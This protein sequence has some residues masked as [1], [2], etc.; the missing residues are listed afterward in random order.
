VKGSFLLFK[1]APDFRGKE[2]KS[3]DIEWHFSSKMVIRI[4]GFWEAEGVPIS[5]K[6]PYI[7]SAKT[8]SPFS[9]SLLY[10]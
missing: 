7:F 4:T 3:F 10:C 2:I 6:E 1:S 9:N 5:T 8:T